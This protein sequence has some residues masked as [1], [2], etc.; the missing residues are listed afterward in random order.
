MIWQGTTYK[1]VAQCLYFDF[2]STSFSVFYKFL[3]MRILKSD[4]FTFGK[5]KQDE[6]ELIE[7]VFF[8]QCYFLNLNY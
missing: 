6:Y 3:N 4:K 7:K 8:V 2:D 5:I 1:L